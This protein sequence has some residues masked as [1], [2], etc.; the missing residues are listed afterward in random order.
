MYKAPVLI[1]FEKKKKKKTKGFVIDWPI[2]L[3]G[4]VFAN[5]SGSV[6]GRDI[7]KTQKMVLDAS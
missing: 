7:P 3:V 4:K 2:G 5:G 1:L 6:P